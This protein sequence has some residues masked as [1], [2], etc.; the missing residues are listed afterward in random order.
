M[1]CVIDMISLV[2]TLWTSASADFGELSRAVEPRAWLR[3]RR[4]SQR[5]HMRQNF[6]RGGRN[7]QVGSLV[8]A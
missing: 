7:W 8:T 1:D 2:I 5:G 6:Q 3:H 4:L